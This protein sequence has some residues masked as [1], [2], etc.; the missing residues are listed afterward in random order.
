MGPFGNINGWKLF[1]SGTTLTGKNI[2]AW[3]G[4]S[5]ML[6]NPWLPCLGGDAAC[7]IA[8]YVD[9]KD[10]NKIFKGVLS[11]GIKAGLW[12]SFC[13]NMDA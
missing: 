9:I 8:V 12:R 11:S 3:K 10:S 4:A 7:F 6:D 1:F 2:W 13:Y 5:G